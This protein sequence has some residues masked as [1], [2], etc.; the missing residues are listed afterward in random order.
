MTVSKHATQRCGSVKAWRRVYTPY[1][2][3][4][5][6]V[7]GAVGSPGQWPGREGRLS[8]GLNR[9]VCFITDFKPNLRGPFHNV[10]LPNEA[11]LLYQR[12]RGVVCKFPAMFKSLPL[13]LAAVVPHWWCRE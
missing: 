13:N 7:S 6:D 8:I 10:Y 12:H 11:P 1:D 2:A 3:V 4:F 9:K 5:G